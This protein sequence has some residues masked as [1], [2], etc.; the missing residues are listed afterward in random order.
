MDKKKELTEACTE[1][2]YEP[3]VIQQSIDL[4]EDTHKKYCVQLDNDIS[5][6]RKQA[7]VLHLLSKTM[8]TE[9]EKI[10]SF[11]KLIDV[12]IVGPTGHRKDKQTGVRSPVPERRTNTIIAARRD[13]Q[14]H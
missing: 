2:S 5:L 13:Q 1:T 12:Q 14:E 8:L 10:Y 11:G 7:Q 4:M 9:N 6:I 3:P